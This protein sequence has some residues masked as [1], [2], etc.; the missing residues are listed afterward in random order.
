M[1][2]VRTRIR[3][4]G[5]SEAHTL[6]ASLKLNKPSDTKRKLSTASS[7]TLQKHNMIEDSES[8]SSGMGILG[9][10]DSLIK[11]RLSLGGGISRDENSK[12]VSNDMV[13]T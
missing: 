12:R 10:R 9:A 3:S 5:I 13:P 11:H 1:E 8:D 4:S 6:V 7:Q 2:N